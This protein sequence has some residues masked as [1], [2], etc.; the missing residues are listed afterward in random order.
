[1]TPAIATVPAAAF[2]S[3]QPAGSVT[4]T[5]LLDVEPVAPAPQPLKLPPNVID[6][7]AGRPDEKP[8]SNVIVST[9][10]AASEPEAVAVKPTVH[11][12]D[13]P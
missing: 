12:V 4:V 5:T 13:A 7:E 3:V 10:P 1:M 11:V 2:A 6:G 9:S 8:L